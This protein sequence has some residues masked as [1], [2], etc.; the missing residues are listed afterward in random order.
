MFD[1]VKMLIRRS[2]TDEQMSRLSNANGWETRITKL[3]KADGGIRISTVL[4]KNVLSEDERYAAVKGRNGHKALS[5]CRLAYDKAGA[6]TI[7]S[8]LPKVG[9]AT[10]ALI[11]YNA[12]H[13]LERLRA[14]ASAEFGVDVGDLRAAQLMR[15]DFSTLFTLERGGPTPREVVKALSDVEVPGK[16]T[17]WIH[18]LDGATVAFH[19]KMTK[20]TIYDKAAECRLSQP[21]AIRDA[22]SKVRFE[23][24]MRRRQIKTLAGHKTPTVGEMLLPEYAIHALHRELEMVGLRRQEIVVSD[25]LLVRLV[26]CFGEEAGLRLMAFVTLIR[27][28]GKTA[29]RA[30][31][32][33]TTYYRNLKMLRDAGIAPITSATSLAMLSLAIGPEPIDERERVNLMW[34]MAESESGDSTGSKERTY[35]DAAA[36]WN[37][38]VAESLELTGQLARR[39]IPATV[40]EKM[41]EVAEHFAKLALLEAQADGE[42]DAGIEGIDYEDEAEMDSDLLDLGTNSEASETARERLAA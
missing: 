14:V 22:Q 1:T 12:D 26:E 41:R 39:R 10:N 9:W 11:L 42:V 29:V 3:P 32:K 30:K 6:L 18:S 5:I 34:A 16:N 28:L 27:A 38:L 37:D 19:G 36:R 21:W 35:E 40:S 33:R 2:L 13:A 4:F 8:S 31:A 15:V 25:A 23:V 7:E 17:Q 20:L 24:Q